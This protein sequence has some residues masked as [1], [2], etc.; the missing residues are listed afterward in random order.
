[1][2]YVPSLYLASARYWSND[3]QIWD[4]FGEIKFS[5]WVLMF[6]STATEWI[7][8]QENVELERPWSAFYCIAK[9]A[10]A[11]LGRNP[12]VTSI[13]SPFASISSMRQSWHSG[14]FCWM[15]C[16]WWDESD[17][18]DRNRLL[19]SGMTFNSSETFGG[20][21]R[22]EFGTVW[23]LGTKGSSRAILLHCFSYSMPFLHTILPLN[24][25]RLFFV[26]PLFDRVTWSLDEVLKQ[27][28]RLQSWLQIGHWWAY[29]IMHLK[30]CENV[31]L[32]FCV[33]LQR[34]EIGS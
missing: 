15:G 24:G 13:W 3:R 18:N 31:S 17:V 8:W 6:T 27:P 32:C 11:Y 29:Y 1:M 22:W 33:Y 4:N 5:L 10:I 28:S 20:K 16:W 19:I 7:E 25:C 26:E 30:R 9:E 21:V 2:Y 23:L 12:V 34:K 14:N